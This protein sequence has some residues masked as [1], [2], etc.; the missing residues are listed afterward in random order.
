MT[1]LSLSL[2]CQPYD[3]VLPL[4]CGMVM[5]EGIDLNYLPLHAIN[6]SGGTIYS[7]NPG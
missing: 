2:A 3:R 4:A 7:G 5:P 6:D 1:K